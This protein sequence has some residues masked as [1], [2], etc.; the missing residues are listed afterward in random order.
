MSPCYINKGR[1]KVGYTPRFHNYNAY[2]TN[3]EKALIYN[4]Q[5]IIKQQDIK[6][7]KNLKSYTPLAKGIYAYQDKLLLSKQLYL[8]R[9]TNIQFINKNKIK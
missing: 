8:H 9:E 4:L 3:I 2:Y 6:K 1:A 7:K 5:Y